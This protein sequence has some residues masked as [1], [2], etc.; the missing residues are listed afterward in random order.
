MCGRYK[1]STPSGELWPYFDV[2]GEQLPLQP[3]FNIAPRQA[4]AVLRAPHRVELVRW[5]LTLGNRK[6]SGINVRV[7]SLRIALYGESIRHRRC[8]ILADGF[9][10]WRTTGPAKQPFLLQR[11]D[12]RPFALAGIWQDALLPNGEVVPAA[13]I[14]T[15]SARGLAAEVHDRMPL[16]LNASSLDQ[17]LDPAARYRP[18]LE[19]DLNGLELVPVSPLVNSPR[20]DDARLIEPVL[21]AR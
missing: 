14:L 19:P 1:L 8:L 7:E 13:A 16:I 9:Y 21:E 17:W 20:N 12:R 15:T 6:G 3:R 11:S 10:E 2:H 4:I 18:L 5:G